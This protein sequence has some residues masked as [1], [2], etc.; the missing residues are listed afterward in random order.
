MEYRV[1]FA[2]ECRHNNIHMNISQGNFHNDNTQRVFKYLTKLLLLSYFTA[3]Y[4]STLHMCSSH[5]SFSQQL[6]HAHACCFEL[7][8]QV[9]DSLG[10]RLLL[11]LDSIQVNIQLF[12]HLTALEDITLTLVHIYDTLSSSVTVLPKR[13]VL[14]RPR[15][16]VTVC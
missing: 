1:Y 2:D 10:L 8:M 9:V 15:V 12:H 16:T 4:S 11:Q 6:I 13:N 14:F 5:S 7:Q 3:Q